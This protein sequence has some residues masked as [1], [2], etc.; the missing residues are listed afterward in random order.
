VLDKYKIDI[1]GRENGTYSP[2]FHN[3]QVVILSKNNGGKL[4]IQ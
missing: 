1:I 4:N 2:P 3:L